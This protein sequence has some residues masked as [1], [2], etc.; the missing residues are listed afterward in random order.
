ML[1]YSGGTG[2]DGA[3]PSA[4]GAGGGGGVPDPARPRHSPS[5]AAE[6]EGLRRE[7]AEDDHGRRPEA[8]NRERQQS[9]EESGHHPAQ[10]RYRFVCFIIVS[11]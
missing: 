1:W 6:G 11:A 8:L 3:H 4:G 10:Q 5:A 9:G 2:G 7:T